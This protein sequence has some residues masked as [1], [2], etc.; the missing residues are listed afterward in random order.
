MCGG[1]HYGEVE[2]LVSV[3]RISVCDVHVCIQS[4]LSC[5]AGTGSEGC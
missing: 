4:R 1:V 3:K 2:G 5:H